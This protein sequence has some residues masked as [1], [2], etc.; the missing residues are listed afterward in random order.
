MHVHWFGWLGVHV[1]GL[2]GD[3]LGVVGLN[4]TW[5]GTHAWVEAVYLLCVQ[6]LGLF[7]S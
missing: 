6:H 1:V 3:E 4:K 2:Y 7:S 5:A